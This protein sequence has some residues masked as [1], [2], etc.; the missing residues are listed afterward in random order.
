MRT[1]AR[2]L[3]TLADRLD[4]PPPDREAAHVH[5]LAGAVFG[6]TDAGAPST[7]HVS[8][9]PAGYDWQLA[10]SWGSGMEVGTPDAPITGIEAE[11]S[12]IVTKTDG[13]WYYNRAS[14]QFERVPT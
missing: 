4:P 14:R 6:V 10:E 7:H 13:L 5:L 8:K 9:C 2:W 3:R 12:L 1:L 11:A